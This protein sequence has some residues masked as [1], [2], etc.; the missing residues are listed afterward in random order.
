M[1]RDAKYFFNADSE[2]IGS[3]LYARIQKCQTWQSTSSIRK[4]YGRAH[5]HSFGAVDMGAGTS[6][7]ITRGGAQGELSEVRVNR[8][9]SVEKALLG[10]LTSAKVVWRPTAVNG[11]TRRRAAV[12]K[13]T[14][15]LEYYWKTQRLNE[16]VI[17]WV[18]Q[19][20][21][22]SE[23]F[24]FAQW[25]WNLGPPAGTGKRLGDLNVRAV[26]PW[27]VFRD[28][29]Y[30]RYE[31][32]PWVVVRVYMNRWDV[33]S[34]YPT[35]VNGESTEGRHTSATDARIY[36]EQGVRSTDDVIPVYFAFHRRSPSMPQ[37]RE[38]VFTSASCV[39]RDSALSYHD[40]P[41]IRFAPENYDGTPYGYTTFFDILGVQEEID[42]LET[43]IATNQLT[44]ATQSVV[45]EEGTVLNSDD[46][47]GMKAIY[48]PKGSQIPQPL[49][50]ASTAPEVFK[51]LDRLNA[52]QRDMMGLNDVAMG[53]PQT[54]QM[55][56][57]A[58]SIL[59]SMAQQRNAPIQ[60]RY[61]D[62]MAK[63]GS[64]IL[65]TLKRFVDEPRS[66]AIA[67]KTSDSFTDMTYSNKDLEPIEGTHVEIGNA[68]EQSVPGRFQL[69]KMY[70]DMGAIKTPDQL[71]QVLESGRMEPATDPLRDAQLLI[72]AENDDLLEGQPV[73]VHF[74]DDHQ[75]HAMM[76]QNLL[77][78]PEVRRNPAAVQAV[79]AHIDEHYVNF[80]G[81]PPGQPA[82]ADP[83]Y[84]VRLKVLLNQQPPPVE[85]APPAGGP[86]EPGNA[87]VPEV[88]QQEQIPGSN[89]LPSPLPQ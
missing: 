80:F 45:F 4:N 12:K 2:N 41:I 75:K 7:A 79:H 61:L 29:T 76:H 68:V 49:S 28:D 48:I 5:M 54:A 11:D 46:V 18:D 24:L 85:G 88:M 16:T 39:L 52:A 78:N 81:L 35:D 58:F 26:L 69:A 71:Q 44:L 65:H 38:V 22:L 34:L 74:G 42:G 14:N 89:E 50:L 51:H 53:Q 84:A 60:Q 3:E 6:A 9:L 25:D 37:G 8:A 57:D 87:P 10:L 36:Q 43:S 13:A 82:G 67:G 55:N 32:C 66:V 23:G 62:A 63:L 64:S 27:D 59:A 86:P 73:V 17:S 40:I 31:D 19:G 1:A 72:S 15:L 30:S 33:E 83:M 20:L 47:A 56:A 77:N 70:T 21:R